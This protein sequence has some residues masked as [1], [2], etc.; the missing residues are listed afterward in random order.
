MQLQDKNG[1]NEEWK[2]YQ[3]RGIVIVTCDL[4]VLDRR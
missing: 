3:L 1:T 2:K 4:K